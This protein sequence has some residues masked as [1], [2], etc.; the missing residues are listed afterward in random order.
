MAASVMISVGLGAFAAAAMVATEDSTFASMYNLA[1]PSSSLILRL[2]SSLEEI[3][4]N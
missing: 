4:Y 2:Y 3:F 1:I